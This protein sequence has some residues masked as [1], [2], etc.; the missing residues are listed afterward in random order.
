MYNLK[1]QNLKI[2]E[3]LDNK[4][5][6]YFGWVLN[7][8]AVKYVKRVQTKEQELQTFKKV[9]QNLINDLNSD[10]K[11]IISKEYKK[12]YHMLLSERE[13]LW[14]EKYKDV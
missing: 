1:H 8:I 5:D 13:F 14:N 4:N 6:N 2:G 7:D 12:M 11:T 3:Y 9:V 10:K